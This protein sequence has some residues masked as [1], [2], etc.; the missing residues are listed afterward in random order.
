M[1]E[2]ARSTNFIQRILKLFN[3]YLSKWMGILH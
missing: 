3:S 1:A 2:R